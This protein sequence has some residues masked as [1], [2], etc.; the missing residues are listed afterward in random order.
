MIDSTQKNKSSLRAALIVS[1][2]AILGFIIWKF[3]IT[4]FVMPVW[5]DEYFTYK[6]ALTTLP[7]TISRVL[8][9]AHPPLYWIIV[10]ILSQFYS[11]FLSLCLGN[12][13]PIR[14]LSAVFG[15]YA[16]Y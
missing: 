6:T 14:I 5:G 12:I 7:D 15:V 2:V 8:N 13:I 3:I 1:A 16:I 9:D 10:N 11:T 4:W